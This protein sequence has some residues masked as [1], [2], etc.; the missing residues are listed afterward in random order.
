MQHVVPAANGTMALADLIE[1]SSDGDEIIVSSEAMRELGERA[2]QRMCPTKTL[3]F[4]VK[5]A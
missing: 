1:K 5:S 2:H 3:T 4:T